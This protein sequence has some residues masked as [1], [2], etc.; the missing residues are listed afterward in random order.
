MNV[1]EIDVEL[2]VTDG[3]KANNALAA[4]VAA[5]GVQVP[6]IA[7]PMGDGR[8]R[9]NSGNRRVDAARRAGLRTVPAII[10]RMD[11]VDY[12]L[13]ELATNVHSRNPVS[14]A[15][16]IVE[17]LAQGVEPDRIK[18]VGGKNA[19][20][21]EAAERLFNSL[22]EDLLSLLIDR[23]LTL[24]AAKTLLRLPKGRQ[25]EAYEAAK[26]LSGKNKPSVRF[27]D[28]VVRE[29]LAESSPTLKLSLPSTD[30]GP[31]PVTMAYALRAIAQRVVDEESKSV[32]LS[33]ADILEREV[34]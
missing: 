16:A 15:I 23:E 25:L 24:S 30:S 3:S 8:Y 13:L 11:Q 22:H 18:E 9:V 27:I 12:R 28:H 32:L 26:E 21:I 20:S 5:I 34:V 33:A 6:I 29:M 31:D 14:D 17:L 2:L 4:S 19:A 1:T 10:A 7:V